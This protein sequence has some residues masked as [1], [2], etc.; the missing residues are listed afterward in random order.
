MSITLDP[1]LEAKLKELAERQG[2]TPEIL[3]LHAL[4]RLGVIP[5]MLNRRTSGNGDYSRHRHGLWYLAAEGI[6]C[7][8][9]YE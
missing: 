5:K 6:P 7:E 4:R 1:E 2:V 9:L 3:A 8:K